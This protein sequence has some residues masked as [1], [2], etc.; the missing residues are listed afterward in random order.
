MAARRVFTGADG[1]G[2]GVGP[3]ERKFVVP[4]DREFSVRNSIGMAE[5]ESPEV[6]E[7]KMY[8]GKRGGD[9]TQRVGTLVTENC[10][11]GR[12]SDAEGIE[13][14]KNGAAFGHE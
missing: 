14:E 13:N 1:S 7:M 2:G 11:V 6:R 12:R 5:A 3:D 4:P 10:G 9:M 8:A